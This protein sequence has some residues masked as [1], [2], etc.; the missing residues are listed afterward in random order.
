MSLPDNLAD[1][2]SGE[3][4]CHTYD[5]P[6]S[7]RNISVP[8]TEPVLWSVSALL[9]L[10]LVLS[11]LGNIISIMA[12]MFGDGMQS[13]ANC[14]IFSLALSDLCSG[15]V[16]PIGIYTR[17]WGFN[18]FLWPRPFC[19][20][21]WAIEE[22][23]SFV[24]SLH[25]ASFA[26]FRYISVCQP[27]RLSEVERRSVI[28]YLI[29]LWMVS[30]LCGLYI[31]S[32]YL[33]IRE[34]VKGECWPQC[35]LLRENENAENLKVYQQIAYP[36][37]Y[38]IPFLVLVISSILICRKLRATSSKSR[39]WRRN[40]NAVV[41]LALVV[42]SFLIGYLP[43]VAYYQTTKHEVNKGEELPE[44]K[45][46]TARRQKFDYWINLSCYFCL[47]LS[48]CMNPFLYNVASTK[49]RKASLRAVG[50]IFLSV[51]G[52]R[53]SIWDQYEKSRKRH[54]NFPE[55][56]ITTNTT[57]LMNSRRRDFRVRQSHS[58]PSIFSSVTA[59]RHSAEKN[60]D[61]L[62]PT[63]W[64]P[65]DKKRPS[66]SDGKAPSSLSN[67]NRSNRHHQLLQSTTGSC[68]HKTSKNQKNSKNH[69]NQKSHCHCSSSEDSI[70]F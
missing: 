70:C 60:K 16:S 4:A 43:H 59:N 56:S 63:S 10:F 19:N 62:H 64:T 28:M 44:A 8:V 15:L 11:V 5:H 51:C 6:W 27:H 31:S 48:E 53:W 33:G 68:D 22:T 29:S 50:R 17:T 24:T 52:F 49:M 55:F 45:W 35:S 54:A 37:F 14:F 2:F 40:R 67:Q 66:S 36:V 3:G 32:T 23:T 26:V 21:Y 20:S 18:P 65:T 9:G 39:N 57:S 7:D 61:T 47:R 12:I 69:K 42:V 58:D 1:Q 34:D 25:I 41:Q 46:E 30:L 38:Y 13:K